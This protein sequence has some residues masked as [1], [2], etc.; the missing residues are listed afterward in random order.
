MTGTELKAQRTRLGLTQL[1]L[2]A[3]L[4]VT[5]NSVA[6]WERGERGISE[7]IAKLV[8]MLRAKKAG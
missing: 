6:R 4:G 7:P 2:A 8:Q 1:E 5:A 3:K